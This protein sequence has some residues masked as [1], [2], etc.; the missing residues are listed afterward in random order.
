MPRKIYANNDKAFSDVLAHISNDAVYMI[1]HG[2]A[3]PHTGEVFKMACVGVCGDW[4]FIRK[5]GYME[6][7]F[8]NIPKRPLT[9]RSIPK[10]ICHLCQAGRLGTPFEDLAAPVPRWL[11]TM[12]QDLPFVADSPLNRIPHQDGMLP[13]LYEFDFFHAFHLGV[14]KTF[15][16]ACIAQASELF[17]GGQIDQRFDALTADY[18][19]WCKATRTSSYIS[20]ISKDN[21]GWPDR[22]TY[23]NGQW[24]KGHVSTVL[25]KWFLHWSRCVDLTG[26]PLLEKSVE[27]ANILQQ[28]LDGLYQGNVFFTVAEGARVSLLGRRFL[29]LYA[30]LALDSHR[31][32]RALFIMMPKIH[33]MDHLVWEM[34][35]C[36]S[37]GR[38]SFN[39]LAW[40]NQMNED[41]ISRPSRLARRVSPRTAI[42]RVINRVLQAMRKHWV[43]AGLLAA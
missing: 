35:A 13:A 12:Y 40:S 38:P 8:S 23:P 14:A 31:S 37:S 11:P 20:C 9:E 25:L 10:G 39:P 19:M 6:R 16:A 41:Y 7:S 4:E 2:V 17:Q 18:M 36:S 5:A 26:H 32:N 28:F 29:S 27:A 42:L 24:S 30:E 33:A 34:Q 1:E 21:I 3:S 22:S 43:D 15:V